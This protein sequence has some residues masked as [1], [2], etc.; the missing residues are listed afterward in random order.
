M[1]EPPEHTD[2]WSEPLAGETEGVDERGAAREPE[3]ARLRVA[4]ARRVGHGPADDVPE[5]EAPQA[6]E[7][8]A[9]FVEAGSETHGIAQSEA[10][11]VHRRVRCCGEPLSQTPEG[12]HGERAVGDVLRGLRR[13]PEQQGTREGAVPGNGGQGLALPPKGGFAP[14]RYLMALSL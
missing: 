13:Q 12:F 3:D 2:R 7:V 5:P 11:D 4:G 8:R 6:V 9:T 1:G 10:P 14:G